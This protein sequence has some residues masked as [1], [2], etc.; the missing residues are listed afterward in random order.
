MMSGVFPLPLPG[1]KEELPLQLI[2]MAIK[3]EPT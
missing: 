3:V 2:Q 1:N